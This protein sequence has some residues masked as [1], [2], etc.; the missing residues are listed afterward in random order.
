[1][2]WLWPT[3]SEFVLFQP[4]LKELHPEGTGSPQDVKHAQNLLPDFQEGQGLASVWPSLL[5]W[6]H[7][8]GWIPEEWEA[9]QKLCIASWRLGIK[10]FEVKCLLSGL[11]KS[12]PAKTSDYES[13]RGS[14]ILPWAVSVLESARQ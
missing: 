1:M 7:A 4:N 8:M 10:A 3:N 13:G 9:W 6:V 14:W 2:H 5:G 11:S 12:P